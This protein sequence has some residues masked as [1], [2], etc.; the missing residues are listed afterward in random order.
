MLEKTLTNMYSIGNA[1]H[2]SWTVAWCKNKW[3]GVSIL[4]WWKRDLMAGYVCAGVWGNSELI[5]QFLENRGFVSEVVQVKL[6]RLV[7]LMEGLTTEDDLFVFCQ[8]VHSIAWKPKSVLIKAYV[9]F[10]L[11]GAS[12]QIVTKI[13]REIGIDITSSFKWWKGFKQYSFKKWQNWLSKS[14]KWL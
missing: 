9:Y 1:L 6:L 13:S 14:N 5:E 12:C 3:D 10:R 11:V 7:R 4:C 2:N 8:I